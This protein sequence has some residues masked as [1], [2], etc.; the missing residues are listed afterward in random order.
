MRILLLCS[1][2]GHFAALQNL[3]SFW[4]RH[5]RIWITFRSPSTER[6]LVNESVYWAFSPT[7]RNLVNLIRNLFLAFKVLFVERPD[8]ILTTGAG[9]AVPFLWIAPL[10]GCQSVFVESITRTKTLS[11]SAR[12]VMPLADVLVQWPALKETYP[13]TI[14]VG[15]IES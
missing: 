12:L 7:N 11:L 14:Y 5:E 3:H 15:A 2:G 9:V 1:S 10:F 13:Q 4:E 8:M 6:Q